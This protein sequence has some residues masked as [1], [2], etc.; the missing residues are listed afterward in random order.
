MKSHPVTYVIFDLLY[1]DGADLTGET[2]QRRREL[3]EG[4][5]LEGES[6]Q[7]PSY[8]VG[9]AKELLAASA[10]R[11]L[12]GIVV[13]RLDSAYAAGKRNGSWLKVKNV[14]RQEFVIGG[15]LPGAG[16]RSG[17]LGS[18]LIGWFDQ[19]GAGD[20]H[21]AGKV[22]TG[23]KERDLEELGARLAPLASDANPFD[24]DKL[25]KGVN[26]VA[27][28]LVAEIEFRELTGEGMVRHGSY[29]GLREDKP[30]S[31]VVLE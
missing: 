29:K 13:K 30:A 18:I 6:W 27:P 2:Y 5:D 16:R 7:T 20:L 4:L 24:A 19:G 31:E 11:G 8:S 25:P 3:L 17:R 14:G 21:Y 9:H 23:F 28:E 15:W 10:E 22:G 1:L 26:F 12:E